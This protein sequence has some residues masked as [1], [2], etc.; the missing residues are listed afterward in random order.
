MDDIYTRAMFGQH[1]R[2]VAFNYVVQDAGGNRAAI[3][4]NTV[5]ADEMAFG[6]LRAHPE[7][8]HV[9]VLCDAIIRPHLVISGR[10]L[11]GMGA[12]GILRD[13]LSSV[14][15]WLEHGKVVI[16]NMPVGR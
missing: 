7:A 3:V 14:D 4:G 2:H 13:G 10:H 9:L 5:L 16:N 15:E 12:S 1:A 11:I 6:A 8:P